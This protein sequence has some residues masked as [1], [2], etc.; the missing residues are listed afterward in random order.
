MLVVPRDEVIDLA[1][2]LFDAFERTTADRLVGNQSKE[3][4]DLVEPGTVGECEVD[5]PARSGCEPGFDFGV[6][7]SAVIVH[8]QMSV[9]SMS[10]ELTGPQP[11]RAL[12]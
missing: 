4:F 8:D 5:V 9:R 11:D 3:A 1:H 6:F 12:L 2:Q 10:P 7:V